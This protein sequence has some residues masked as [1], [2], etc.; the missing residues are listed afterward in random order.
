VQ[1]KAMFSVQVKAMFSAQVRAVFSAQVK[2]MF[3]VQVKAMFSARDRRAANVKKSEIE[4]PFLYFFSEKIKK[5]S[6]RK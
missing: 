1:V 3:S 6:D 4:N 5:I 2:A